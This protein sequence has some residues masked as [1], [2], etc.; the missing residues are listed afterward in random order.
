LA[1][2]VLGIVKPAATINVAA[3]ASFFILNLSS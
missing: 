1:N 2:A 3:S